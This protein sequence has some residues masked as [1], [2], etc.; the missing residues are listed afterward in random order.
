[1][2]MSN[3]VNE[4]FKALSKA[5]GELAH[6]EKNKKSHTNKYA[7][8][9]AC[10]DAAK[11]PLKDNGLAVTQMLGNKEG[12]S[13]LITMLCH[14]SGQYISSEF[15]MEKAVL[16]GSGAN[17]PA[18]KMGASI[19]YARRYAFAA[20]IG[21]A[22]EDD[23]A[24][25]MGQNKQPRKQQQQQKPPQQQGTQKAPEFITPDQNKYLQAYF[26]SVGMD[27]DA[28]LAKLSEAL[29]RQITTT[30]QVTKE[31]ASVLIDKIEK[32]KGGQNA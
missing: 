13:T 6:A 31:E 11:G 8:I 21:L 32:S 15:V 16:H 20:L 26:S 12:E 10:I 25:S 23:D 14:E 28:K 27:R 30:S 1:M 24:A 19:T 5:Q 22:Q 7:D 17:N 18:Q 9:A 29:G 4:L 2:K 3:E